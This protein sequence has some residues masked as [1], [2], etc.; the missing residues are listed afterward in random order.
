MLLSSIIR[1]SDSDGDRD[2]DGTV[3]AP[4]DG[5]DASDAAATIRTASRSE[6]QRCPLY[7][8]CRWQSAATQ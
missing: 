8:F 7:R 2:S 6:L 3:P 5:D 4:G 1:D